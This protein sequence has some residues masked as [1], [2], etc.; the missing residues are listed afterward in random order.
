VVDIQHRA[1]CALQQHLLAGVDA[2]GEKGTRVDEHILPD[3]ALAVLAVL[4]VQRL[5]VELLADL[6]AED[7]LGECPLLG[8]D[9]GEAL[10]E[11][12]GVG[13]VRGADAATAGLVLVGRADSPARRADLLVVVALDI[14]LDTVKCAV[15]REDDVRAPRDAHVRVEAALAQRI[16][17]VEQRPG[18]HD[19]AVAEDADLAADCA[20]WHQREF[21]LLAA[22]DDGVARVVPALVPGDDVRW[23][24]EHIDDAAFP[25]VSQLCADDC[26]GHRATLPPT[27]VNRFR[28]TQT[29]RIVS[30]PRKS[31]RCLILP[32]RS[33]WGVAPTN[34]TEGRE[35]PDRGPAVSHLPVEQQVYCRTG[36][37]I[38][39]VRPLYE[40][41]GP[42]RTGPQS[43]DER[44]G[45]G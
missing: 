4:L 24:A 38:I 13:Q 20:A 8:D 35:E 34:W 28:S 1:L 45:H 15:V 27:T 19:T 25:L 6:D 11:H 30:R 17:F 7:R 36:E 22:V 10:A 33:T 3:Q 26:D 40:C 31:H 37:L 32:D 39:S 23:L 44:P 41:R 21:V 43:G 5:Q 16:Q 29:E 12:L 9:I 18:V 2:V 42:R 14:L